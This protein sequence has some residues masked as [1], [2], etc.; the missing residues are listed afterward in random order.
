MEVVENTSVDDYFRLAAAYWGSGS[1]AATC[2]NE[3][4]QHGWSV[5]AK[6]AFVSLGLEGSGHHLV[7]QLSPSLCGH[8]H[9]RQYGYGCGGQYSYPFCGTC[10]WQSSIAWRINV[11]A[12]VYNPDLAS[13]AHTRRPY[14]SPTAFPSFVGMKL[15]PP[16]KFVVLVRDP[17]DTLS[18]ALRRYWNATYEADTL[19]RELTVFDESLHELSAQVD[20]LPCS[21]TFFLAYELLTR[22]PQEHAAA[23][24]AFLSVPATDALL[25]R[26]VT[27]TIK[28]RDAAKQARQAWESRSVL[29]PSAGEDECD[30]DGELARKLLE[31]A[32]SAS[33]ERR[34]SAVLEGWPTPECLRE[35]PDAL[36]C[37]AAFRRAVTARLREPS[38]RGRYSALMPTATQ[39]LCLREDESD[40]SMMPFNVQLE[41]ISSGGSGGGSGGG[42][43]R[44]SSTGGGTTTTRSSSSRSRSSGSSGSSGS[45]G[46][47]GSSGSGGSGGSSGS[48]GSG[49]SRYPHTAAGE[50]KRALGSA[51]TVASHRAENSA[52]AASV[53]PVLHFTGPASRLANSSRFIARLRKCAEL[54]PGWVVR[55]WT[56]EQAR[57]IVEEVRSH[58]EASACSLC[59]SLMPPHPIASLHALR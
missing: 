9:N 37:L 20:A 45:G 57:P 35:P 48:G 13:L 33:R 6:G 34:S 32:A 28:P 27:E 5:E 36:A 16:G 51:T 19:D 21:R 3:V 46:S 4:R 50:P 15:K 8:Q 43:D 54:N 24:A 56:D 49:S 39:T 55:T 7:E 12:T 52:A 38:R 17:V 30:H 42:S 26:F 41:G 18:S 10:R 23:L 2:L 31:E 11:T 25:Q 29:V 58:P 59:T 1:R 53:P 22:F 44:S 47:G 40:S 14:S